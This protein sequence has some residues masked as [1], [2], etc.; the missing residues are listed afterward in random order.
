MERVELNGADIEYD[1]RGS[2]APVVFIHGAILSDG[3][4]PVI[5]QTGIAENFQIVHYRRRGYAGSSRALAGMTMQGWAGDC[6]ALSHVA[7]H[8]F[9]AGIALQMAIDAPGRVRKLALLE[10]PLLSLVPSG[11]QFTEWAASVGEIYDSGDRTAATDMVL[12]GAYGRDYRRFTDGALPAGAFERAVS[13]SSWL[14]E[15]SL[16]S[17]VFGDI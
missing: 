13:A 5:E 11:E 3:F 2:G 7:G 17:T 8:S 10:P 4:V 9:G 6:I 1:V 14:A 12:A 16:R 15:V